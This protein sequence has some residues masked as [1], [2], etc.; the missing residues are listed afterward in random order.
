MNINNHK[1][2]KEIEAYLIKNQVMHYR[3]AYSYVRNE[4]DALDIIQEAS[5]KAILHMNSLK[6]MQQIKPWFCRIIINTALDFLRKR[7]RLVVM[8]EETLDAFDE[9]TEDRY[10]NIDLHQALNEMPDHYRSILIL[11]FF[12]DLKLEEIAGILDENVNTI[13]SRLY[14]SLK[15]L[16]LE[17]EQ[18]Q[19]VL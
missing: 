1:L 2:E 13:K 16:R 19:E 15:M 7:K 3:L 6:N 4:D 5:C 14:R 8:D 9:G 11:R 10:E 17:I 18:D 12:E